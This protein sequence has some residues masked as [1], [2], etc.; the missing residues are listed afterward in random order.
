MDSDLTDAQNQITELNNSLSNVQL[1]KQQMDSDLTDAQN[2]IMELNDSL[3][4]VQLQKQQTHSDLQ[5]QIDDLNGSLVDAQSQIVELSAKLRSAQEDKEQ[6]DS[7]LIS[8]QRNKDLHSSLLDARKQNQQ[9]NNRTQVGEAQRD[10]SLDD[11]QKGL[12]VPASV[13]DIK[14]STPLQLPRK[15]PPPPTTDGHTASPIPLQVQPIIVKVPTP[16][17]IS[18]FTS[19]K[20]EEFYSEFNSVAEHMMW[21]AYER[22]HQLKL[23]LKGDARSFV[24]TV[25][26]ERV[27]L[28]YELLVEALE[29]QYK[30]CTSTQNYLLRLQNV[31]FTLKDSVTSYIQQIKS[32]VLK[33]FP[34]LKGLGEGAA[35]KNI[36]LAYF[37]QGIQDPGLNKQLNLATISTIEEAREFVEKY[38]NLSIPQP[39]YQRPYIPTR[40]TSISW[41]EDDE[42][43]EIPSRSSP[44]D[45]LITMGSLRKFFEER[46]KPKGP[47]CYRCKQYG[48]I[49]PHCPAQQGNAEYPQGAKDSKFGRQHNKQRSRSPRRD[50]FRDG[51]QNNA[52]ARPS[53]VENGV[54]IPSQDSHSYNAQPSAHF[55]EN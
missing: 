7:S 50:N 41:S 36:E 4:N 39:K 23:C 47:Q 37:K 51:H 6:M 29:R 52:P 40:A 44:D 49:R 24:F 32:G 22:C 5:Q 16:P 2:Q 35:L 53:R 25:C 30:D 42:I 14:T 43:H 20:W 33:A 10:S 1:E 19:N 48:H 26:S 27:R 13:L 9:L 55:Q 28:S 17:N 15:A 3:S 46:E 21:D 45:E 31:K 54:Y 11:A 34:E 18:S 38:V 8:A 12:N